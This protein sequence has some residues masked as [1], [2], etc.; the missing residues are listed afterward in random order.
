MNSFFII[1]SF[2]IS[3]GNNLRNQKMIIYRLRFI[4]YTT[5]IIF[6]P[7]WIKKVFASTILFKVAK[8]QLFSLV[9]CCL[10]YRVTEE[11]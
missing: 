8:L 3:E 5:F 4:F 10:I 7:I 11:A 2:E 6:G 1:W 9:P